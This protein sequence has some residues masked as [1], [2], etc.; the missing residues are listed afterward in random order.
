MSELERIVARCRDKLEVLVVFLKPLETAAGWEEA[1]L[2]RMAERIPNVRIFRDK[3]GVETERFQ[4][5]ISGMTLLYDSDG[6]LAFR[7][8]ITSARGHEGDNDGRRAVVSLVET[9]IARD[10]AHPVFG[11]RLQDLNA[12]AP[13]AK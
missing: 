13:F 8:G 4:A 6:S 3:G 10:S 7:G 2:W 5:V 11:C 1:E 12:A 9:G